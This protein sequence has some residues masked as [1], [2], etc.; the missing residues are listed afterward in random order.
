MNPQY[1]TWPAEKRQLET[2][3]RAAPGKY[4]VEIGCFRGCTTQFLGYVCREESKHLIGI[5]PWDN[6]QDQAAD[7][8][9]RDCLAA[10]EPVKDYVTL[11]KARSDDVLMPPQQNTSFWGI[12]QD[13]LWPSDFANNCGFVF[14]DGDHSFEGALKDLRLYY[15]VLMPGGVIAI[16]DALDP[17]WPG[18]QRAIYTF[19]QQGSINFLHYLPTPEEQVEY[20]HG[21]S[22]L[23]WFTKD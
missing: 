2:L 21:G 1:S 22:G 4:A 12:Q 16:H 18:V 19:R 17:G 11:I 15:D 7:D 14:V 23:A 6:L 13:N 10:V 20:Q 9:Y 5:D 3:L 8:V